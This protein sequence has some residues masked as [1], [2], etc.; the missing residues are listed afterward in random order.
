MLSVYLWSCLKVER[1]LLAYKAHS[2]ADS[3]LFGG[4]EGNNDSTNIDITR[5]TP[6]VPTLVVVSDGVAIW[7]ALRFSYH[8]SNTC[9]GVPNAI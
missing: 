2:P 5:D 9:P 4:G 3:L 7:L 6:S 1:L 8:Y